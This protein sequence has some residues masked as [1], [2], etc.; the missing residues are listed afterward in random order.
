V[1]FRIQDLMI[2][3]RPGGAGAA[4]GY[5][6]AN[7]ECTC[8]ITVKTGGAQRQPDTRPEKPGRRP[9]GAPGVPADN[10]A[11]VDTVL[12]SGDCPPGARGARAAD[13]AALQ[14][15]LRRSLGAGA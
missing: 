9:D 7:P 11:C 4:G 8:Q 5:R 10:P 14:R 2:A 15:E 12:P 6:M 1:A 13:L 3:V